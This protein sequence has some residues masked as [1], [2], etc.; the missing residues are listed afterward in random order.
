MTEEEIQEF[1]RWVRYYA[2]LDQRTGQSMMNA[3]AA[4]AMPLY[5]DITGTKYDI[6][7]RTDSQDIYRFREYL[8]I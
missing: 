1:W 7:H 2:G 6:F 4:V 5:D 3:L 8:G